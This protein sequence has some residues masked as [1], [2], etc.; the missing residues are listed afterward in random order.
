MTLIK[1]H[2]LS[3]LATLPLALGLASV[4]LGAQDAPAPTQAPDRATTADAQEKGAEAL[5]PN[6]SFPT[7]SELVGL[8][9]WGGTSADRRADLGDVRDIVVNAKTGAISY[10]IISSGG[11]GDVGDT[12]RAISWNQVK[13][14]LDADRKTVA[15][16]EMTEEQFTAVPEFKAENLDKMTGRGA[17]EAAAKRA[18][19]AAKDWTEDEK[20]ANAASAREAMA[21]AAKS[22]LGANLAGLAITGPDGGEAYSEVAELVIDQD[23][24]T[25]AFITMKANDGQLLVPFGALKVATV[26]TDRD[27]DPEYIVHC[28][29]TEADVKASVQIDASKGSQ[30]DQNNPR[31]RAAVYEFYGL[32][33]PNMPLNAKV[34]KAV[35]AGFDKVRKSVDR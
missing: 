7:H 29:K 9:L 22:H 16:V 21:S 26:E 20:K 14:T 2:H 23:R 10:V 35:G 13:W 3:R 33:E 25:I 31:F 5:K 18:T 27:A 15:S 34:K 6:R 28:N 11:A 24:G 32:K 19:D 30:R 17:V 4:T 1:T 8:D 12:L